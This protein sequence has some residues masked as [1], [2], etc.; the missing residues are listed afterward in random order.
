MTTLPVSV[1]T[2]EKSFSTLRRI[3]S[4]LTS[5]M[6]EDGLSGL[7]FLQVYKNVP[8]VPK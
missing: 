8:I 7:A 6:A 1:A 5:L 2:A 4:W 3:K